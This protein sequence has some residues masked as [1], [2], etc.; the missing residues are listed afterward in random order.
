[1]LSLLLWVV[2]KLSGVANSGVKWT[3][4]KVVNS[5]EVSKEYKFGTENGRALF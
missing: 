4:K 2:E 1:M 5:N 3:V